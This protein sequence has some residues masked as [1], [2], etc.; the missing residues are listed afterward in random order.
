VTAT[1]DRD[2]S[3]IIPKVAWNNRKDKKPEGNE[4]VAFLEAQDVEVT[5]SKEYQSLSIKG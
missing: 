3:N 4:A 2:H 1:R 5:G